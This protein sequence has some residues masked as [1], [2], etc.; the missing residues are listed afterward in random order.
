[1]MSIEILRATVAPFR[2]YIDGERIF[3]STV[4]AL[5]LFLALAALVLGIIFLAL[6]PAKGRLTLGDGLTFVALL[7]TVASFF[8]NAG[9][10]AE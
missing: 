4:R 10:P 1:M 3:Q 8:A 7:L 2:A 6:L 5:S 9:K